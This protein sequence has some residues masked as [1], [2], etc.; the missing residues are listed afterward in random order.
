MSSALAPDW[1]RRPDALWAHLARHLTAHAHR[2]VRLHHAEEDP[3]AFAWTR[4]PHGAPF[5]R[6]AGWGVGARHGMGGPLFHAF[7]GPGGPGRGPRMRRGDVRAAILALLQEQ[8]RNGY[9]VIQEI[10]RRSGGLWRASAGSVYPALQQLQD[11][12]LVEAVEEGGRRELRLTPEGTRYAQEH[13][14]E[15]AAPWASVADSIDVE[16]RSLFEVMAAVAAAAVQVAQAGNA[17]QVARAREILAGTRRAL[18][19]I[20][21][22]EGDGGQGGSPAA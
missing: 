21:A 15:L 8:P 18:Y 10:E 20:L 6:G 19:R 5:G 13:P 4:A 9:Q 12:G 2:G 17:A 11:E 3:S 16:A 1:S 22:E 7:F 14:E